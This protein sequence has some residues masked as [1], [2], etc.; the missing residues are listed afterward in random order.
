M[1]I[2]IKTE[3]QLVKSIGKVIE[4]HR[5]YKNALTTIAKGWHNGPAE[6]FA[7]LTL[8]LVKAAGK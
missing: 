7:R 6:N 3:N 2:A 8:K 5:L 4:E 1:A